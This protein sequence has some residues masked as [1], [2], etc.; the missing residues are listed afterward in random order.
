M[1]RLY[2]I[3]FSDG[4]LQESI[5]QFRET[6]KL[7]IEI[8]DG[9][10]DSSTIETLWAIIIL[11]RLPPSFSVMRTLQ[12]AQYKGKKAKIPMDTFLSDLEQELQRQSE[13]TKNQSPSA[14]SVTKGQSQNKNPRRR[15]FWENGTHNPNT[16]HSPDQCF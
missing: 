13:T 2:D 9:S 8:S 7:L 5:N 10:L 4:N 3:Q 16:A 6:F 1:D 11:K 12:F 14:F 15:P